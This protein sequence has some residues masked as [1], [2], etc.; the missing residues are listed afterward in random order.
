MWIPPQKRHYTESCNQDRDDDF[1]GP[2]PE[3][4]NWR[5]TSGQWKLLRACATRGCALE[6]TLTQPHKMHAGCR[7]YLDRPIDARIPD[8]SGDIWCWP[9]GNAR[10]TWPRSIRLLHWTPTAAAAP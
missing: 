5:T 7:V 2:V 8:S 6:G 3:H 9:Q 4:F 10:G 1:D